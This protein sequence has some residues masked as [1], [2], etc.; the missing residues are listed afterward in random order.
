[1]R[2][3]WKDIYGIEIEVG[4]YV[5]DM[6]NG[7]KG[8]I[9]FDAREVPCIHVVEQFNP[10]VGW[11]KLNNKGPIEAYQRPLFDEN[12]SKFY[13]WRHHYVLPH[14]AVLYKRYN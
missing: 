6:K 9:E 10:D 4:D 12:K 7:R 1:M 5:K 13:W 14:I 11:R 2:Y 3:P 8:Y